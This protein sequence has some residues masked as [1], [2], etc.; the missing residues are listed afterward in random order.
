MIRLYN[1]G[2]LKINQDYIILVNL[3][4]SWE[5]T[6]KILQD[7]THYPG[8]DESKNKNSLSVSFLLEK[9]VAMH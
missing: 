3:V 7:P 1:H 5:N 6:L 8:G 9:V 2:E 4:N